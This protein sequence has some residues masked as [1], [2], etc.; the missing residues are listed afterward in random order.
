MDEITDYLNNSMIKLKSNPLIKMLSNQL[1][2][3]DET[4]ETPSDDINLENARSIIENFSKILSST[5]T[6]LMYNEV[7]F[8]EQVEELIDLLKTNLTD[9]INLFI[10]KIRNL[11]SNIRNSD[12]IYRDKIN[13]IIGLWVVATYTSDLE[14]PKDIDEICGDTDKLNNNLGTS[15]DIHMQIID[16]KEVTMI[17]KINIWSEEIIDNLIK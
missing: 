7:Y 17:R 14:I 1:G 5:W 3:L 2:N 15:H 10:E 13:K 8:H 12:I 11:F 6:K 4:K 9:M 16:E